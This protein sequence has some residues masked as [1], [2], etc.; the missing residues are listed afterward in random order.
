MMI[1]S[2]KKPGLQPLFKR[3]IFGK[4]RGKG[5]EIDPQPLKG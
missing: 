3:H 2:H 1:L 4:R 5:G